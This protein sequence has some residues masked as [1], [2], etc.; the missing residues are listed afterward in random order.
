VLA[1]QLTYYDNEKTHYG[2]MLQR[3]GNVKGLWRRRDV[4]VF[5]MCL[6]SD[7]S[8]MATQRVAT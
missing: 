1:T 6:Q 7:G 8:L 3:D 5:A 4:N 2:N